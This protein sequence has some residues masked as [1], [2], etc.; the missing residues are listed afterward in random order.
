MG[1]GT[2]IFIS[3]TR[4]ALENDFITIDWVAAYPYPALALKEPGSLLI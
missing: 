1:T 4:L 3:P 2:I